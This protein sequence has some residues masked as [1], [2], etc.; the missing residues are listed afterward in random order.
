MRKADIKAE[1]NPQYDFP[2][3]HMDLGL[4]YDKLGKK[5]ERNEQYDKAI[6]LVKNSLPGLNKLSSFFK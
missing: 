1:L 4:F 3:I 2:E 5:T 6:D